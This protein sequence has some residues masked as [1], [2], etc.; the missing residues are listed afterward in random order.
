MS[1]RECKKQI[2]CILGM[3]IIT[4]IQ[5]ENTETFPTLDPTIKAT[6]IIYVPVIERAPKLNQKENFQ[7]FKNS[8]K[9]LNTLS[10]VKFKN[11]RI[12]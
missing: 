6:D 11:N 2:I 1:I 7:G 8:S 3:S 4:K 9:S 12:K 10:K 5:N